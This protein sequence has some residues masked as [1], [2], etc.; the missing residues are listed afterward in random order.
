MDWNWLLKAG[1]PWLNYKERCHLM[2]YKR[3]HVCLIIAG[4]LLAVLPS[5]LFAQ[6]QDSLHLAA[7]RQYAAV[8]IDSLHLLQPGF[9]VRLSQPLNV[10][11]IDFRDLARGLGAQHGVNIIVQP[12]IAVRVTTLL[13]QVS[14]LEVL[15]LLGE[16]YGLVLKRRGVAV[17]VEVKTAPPP[18]EPI[19][20]DLVKISDR[21]LVVDVEAMAVQDFAR[22]V[23]DLTGLPIIVRPTVKSLLTGYLPGV[24]VR[25]GLDQFL[26]VNGLFLREKDGILT[27]DRRDSGA[28]DGGKRRNF[29][30]SI[31]KGLV[32]IDVV[33]APIHDVIQDIASQADV[34][35]VTYTQS[36]TQITAK[37]SGLTLDQ[38]LNMLLR[39]TNL[40]FRSTDGVYYI[41]DKK[42]NGIATT[43]L[44]A[45]QHLRADEV[46]KSL[47]EHFRTQSAL[48]IVK[49]HNG[50]MA[51]GSNDVLFELDNYLKEIDRPTPQ[52]LIEAL[53]LDLETSSAYE[54]G[55]TAGTGARPA[56]FH[57]VY[58][59]FG[60]PQLTGGG[61][62]Q[63]QGKNA[64]DALNA[65]GAVLGVRNMGVLPSDFYFRLN[66]LSQ[67]GKANIRSRPQ[68]STLNGHEASLSIGTTQYFILKTVTPIVSPNQ[69]FTQEAQRFEKI[70][71]NV[72]LK[73]KPWVSSSGEV[74][75]EINPEFSTPVG[76]FSAETPPTINTRVLNS[77]VRLKDGETII[78]GGLIQ[79]VTATK[80]NRIPFLGGI[81]WFGRLFRFKS[82]STQKNEL[83]ILLTPY[84][85]YGDAAE[86]EKWARLKATVGGKDGQ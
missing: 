47:P 59:Q 37:T 29:W 74:T 40:T 25:A 51:I 16:Q 50:I 7:L 3:V 67:R 15:A 55:F 79:D 76:T 43:R 28:D 46:L 26:A 9:F 35:I 30:V 2:L 61:V 63:G 5:N 8:Q 71:A 84:V 60:N 21:K 32:S 75:A 85:F 36:N 68:I 66:A 65:V 23:S 80:E 19:K 83:I 48:H 24:P 82:T 6:K 54:L 56:A 62:V 34:N 73:I 72:S 1:Q 31:E 4:W 69:S 39:N 77:T 22:R 38:T 45:L 70:E 33:N 18:V 58:S 53:V 13:N 78:L 12:G 27:I 41:G 52:I 81:P 44:L 11:D 57:G 86:Q 20:K 17:V 64:N 14:V 42:T 49:E 10:K